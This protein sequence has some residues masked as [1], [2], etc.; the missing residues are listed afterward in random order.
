MNSQ[1]LSLIELTVVIAIL[2]ITALVV[3][4]NLSSS[5]AQKIDLAANSIAEAIRFARSESM[6]LRKPYGIDPIQRSLRVRVFRVNTAT[7]PWSAVKD[8][9]HPVS[10]KLYDLQFTRSQYRTVTLDSLVRSSSY[11]GTCQS[12]RERYYFDTN[13]SPWCLKPANIPLNWYKLILSLGSHTRTVT[14]HGPS[15]RVSV[16]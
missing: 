5:D 3:I 8:V 11:R 13:G 16:E 4:P 15:G 10:K 9:Y 14:L 7:S 1:G 12:S 6:R 2:G